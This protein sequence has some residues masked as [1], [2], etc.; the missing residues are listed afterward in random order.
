MSDQIASEFQ[1][2]VPAHLDVATIP[3][4]PIKRPHPAGIQPNHFPADVKKRESLASRGHL[5]HPGLVLC[6]HVRSSSADLKHCL[7]LGVCQPESSGLFPFS[8]PPGGG[9][10]GGATLSALDIFRPCEGYLKDVLGQ[11]FGK[12]G[13]EGRQPRVRGPMCHFLEIGCGGLHQL[14]D[15]S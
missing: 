2:S 4:E 10:G 3:T 1:P 11:G 6:A 13:Q 8:L 14:S 15:Q 9:E 5:G 7:F 12:E